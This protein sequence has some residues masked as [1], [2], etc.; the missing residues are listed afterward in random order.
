[1]SHGDIHTSGIPETLLNATLTRRGRRRKQRQEEE[2]KNNN[3]NKKRRTKWRNICPLRLHLLSCCSTEIKR[4][5]Q[6][7]LRICL[8][9]RRC[10]SWTAAPTS[11]FWRSWTERPCTASKPRPSSCGRPRAALVALWNVSL[12]SDHTGITSLKSPV[13]TETSSV[14]IYYKC[15]C[16]CQCLCCTWTSRTVSLASER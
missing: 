4:F 16:L 3:N 5:L 15:V 8:L 12:R 14:R 7:Q 10:M 11:C 2:Q 1:M 9:F 13:A 6:L